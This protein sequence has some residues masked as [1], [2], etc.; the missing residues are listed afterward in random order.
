MQSKNTNETPQQAF[1]RWMQELEQRIQQQQL[2]V[3]LSADAM[4]NRFLIA[5]DED[6]AWIE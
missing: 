5:Y 1:T 6:L 4:L 3:N 2:E